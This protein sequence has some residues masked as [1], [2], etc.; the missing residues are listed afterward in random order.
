MHRKSAQGCAALLICLAAGGGSAVAGEAPGDQLLSAKPPQAATTTQ[1][2]AGTSTIQ[3]SLSISWRALGDA[4]NVAADR[5]AGPRTGTTRIG[6]SVAQVGTANM[7]IGVPQGCLDF[8]WHVNASRNGAITAKR[9][10]EGVGFAIPVKFAGN[11]GFRGDLAKALQLNNKNFS[12]AF[13]VTISGALKPDKT[14]CPRLDQAAAHFAWTT[15]PQ[16]DLVKKTCLDAGGGLKACLGPWTLPVGAMLT[17]EINRSLAAQ[18]N[19]INGR[20]PCNDI[21]DAL[22]KVWKPW[23]FAVTL[24]NSPAFFVNVEPKALFIPGVVANDAGVTMAARLDAATSVSADRPAALPPPPLPQNAP[25]ASQA[26]KF[27]LHV[28]LAV[29]YG[30]LASVPSGSIVGKPIRGRSAAIA[31]TKIEMFASNEKLA[32]GVTF[33]ADAPAKFRGQTGTVWFTATP[34]IANDGHLIRLND[35]AMTQKSNSRLW[36]L[37]PALGQLPK[38]VGGAY[39][40]DLG[41]LVREAQTRLHQAIADPKNTA[42]VNIAIA[43]DSL[44][45]GRTALLATAFVVEGDFDADVSVALGEPRRQA[46]G[47]PQ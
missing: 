5:F 29:P 3:P 15:P 4:A 45:L 40:Y 20:I 27:S 31:P 24:P 33:R 8:D 23:S 10:G 37:A 7:K 19:E 13:V 12:G 16:I 11:G 26:G 47:A 14:F 30:L 39:S 32:I 43:N 25:L 35:L 6:C 1:F 41:P 9:D 18:V 2:E 21:R 22:Q 28:P 44:K 46:S 17:G 36:A 34:A 38:A 42:G